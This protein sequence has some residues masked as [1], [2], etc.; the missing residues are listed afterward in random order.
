[1]R[2]LEAE[3]KVG[4]GDYISA[5][6]HSVLRVEPYT[7]C[8]FGCAYCY[9]RW[10]RPVGS[11][12]PKPWLPRALEKLWSKLPRGLRL[13]PFRLSTLVDPLQPLE[14]EHKMT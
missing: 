11:P 8:W 1:M 4:V 12:R 6:C 14:E 2:S 7:S 3:L 10:E 5:L 13:L 9:A